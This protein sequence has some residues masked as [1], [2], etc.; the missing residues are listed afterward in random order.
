MTSAKTGAKRAGDIMSRE[1]VCVDPA[2]G[3]AELTRLFSEHEIS[4]APVV[5]AQ[6]RLI[7]VVSRTDIM[8][9]TLQRTRAGAP[10]YFFEWLDEQAGEP[11][12]F[13][14]DAEPQVQDCMTEGAV[15]ARPDDSLAAVARRM[16]EAHVH[17]VIV[18]DEENIPVGV[19]TSLDMLGAWSR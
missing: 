8:R 11:E 18:V 14:P 4:G 16:S 15:T 17:R 9:R 12:E 6:G 10:A 19:V 1:P 13:E 7:G 2:A 5:D 3:V